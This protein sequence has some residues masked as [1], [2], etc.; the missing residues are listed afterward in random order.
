MKSIVTRTLSIN[1][2]YYLLGGI[3][4]STL[5]LTEAEKDSHINSDLFSCIKHNI[6]KSRRVTVANLRKWNEI[7]DL[8]SY[9]SI[10]IVGSFIYKPDIFVELRNISRAKLFLWSTEDP[11]EL[12]FT[13]NNIKALDRVFTN[14][15]NLPI[16]YSES[17]KFEYLPFGVCLNCLNRKKNNKNSRI[18]FC[19]SGFPERIAIFSKLKFDDPD[20]FSNIDFVG[21]GW[22]ELVA[23]GNLISKRMS[24]STLASYYSTYLINLNIERFIDINREFIKIPNSGINTRIL[25]IGAC[26]GSIIS[27]N[28]GYQIWQEITQNSI[29]VVNSYSRFIESIKFQLSNPVVSMEKGLRLQSEIQS[30]FSLDKR[31]DILMSRIELLNKG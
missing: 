22:D 10:V 8:E 2:F 7:L 30:K 6:P 12:S 9:E 31:V 18:L 3:N 21:E 24:R 26:G 25:E 29:T 28:S 20:L 14:D 17:D 16:L 4:M 15:P 11:Y 27:L 1:K 5:I 23:P 13:R 19:G